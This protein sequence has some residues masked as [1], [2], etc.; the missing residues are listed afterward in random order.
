MCLLV[1]LKQCNRT[2]SMIRSIIGLCQQANVFLWWI[3]SHKSF[4]EKGSTW[5]DALMKKSIHGIFKALLHDLV[6][7]RRFKSMERT[8]DIAAVVPKNAGKKFKLIT[9]FKGKIKNRNGVFCI[10]KIIKWQV[11][12]III[13]S[14]AATMNSTKTTATRTQMRKSTRSMSTWHDDYLLHY[15]VL[16]CILPFFCINIDIVEPEIAILA[17]DGSSKGLVQD[18]ERGTYC[19]CMC[20]STAYRDSVEY[21]VGRM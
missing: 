16:F 14:A 21:A 12:N 19:C 7:L 18:L 10:K 3:F 15:I 8:N 11:S 6:A 9:P 2:M 17:R 5:V 20:T 4:S 13:K 1:A